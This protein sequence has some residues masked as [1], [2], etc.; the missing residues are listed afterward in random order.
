MFSSDCSS[1]CE[2]L[3]SC[4]I[5]LLLLSFLS[6]PKRPTV[7]YQGQEVVNLNGCSN[8]SW[9]SFTFG[10]LHQ[11]NAA[12]LPAKLQL[13]DVPTPCYQLRA[14]PLREQFQ[15]SG[16]GTKLWVQLF[17]SCFRLLIIEWTLVVCKAISE[18]GSRYALY[19]LL[20]CLE[21]DMNSVREKGSWAWAGAM[22]GCLLGEVLA[23]TWL[24]WISSGVLYNTATVSLQTLIFEKMTRKQHT[25]STTN[26]ESNDHGSQSSPS[27][28][29][30]MFNDT[31]GFPNFT[32]AFSYITN[33]LA[34][35]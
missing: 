19:R 1:W 21:R 31:Y 35:T 11:T 25:K 2:L 3:L 8:I 18:F 33:I 6:I 26:G 34:A 23:D 32:R 16:K 27:T 12:N 4:A 24:F 28:T 13:S 17:K 14:K 7:Y 22:G 5:P 9:L 30:M 10:F 29:D 15:A 20:Q